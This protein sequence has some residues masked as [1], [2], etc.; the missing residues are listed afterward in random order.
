MP[1][2][3]ETNRSRTTAVW[4]SSVVRTFCV[5]TSK[6]TIL[7]SWESERRRRRRGRVGHRDDHIRKL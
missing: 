1:S 2:S 4:P 3:F 6:T 5:A 7:L